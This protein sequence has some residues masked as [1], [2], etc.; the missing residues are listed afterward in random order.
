[1]TFIPKPQQ[2]LATKFNTLQILRGGWY[3]TW[4]ASFLLLVI[5]II[6]INQQRNSIKTVGTDSAPS[7]LTA[8]Q[9]RDSFADLDA[10][11]ANELLAK[12][13]EDP[14]IIQKFEDNRKKIAERLVAAGKNITYPAEE[15]IIQD[16][17]LGSSGYFLK[18]QAARDAHT[19]KDDVAALNIYRSAVSLLERDILPQA[20]NLDRVNSQELEKA[21]SQQ[22]A[23]SKATILSIVLLGIAQIGILIALQL[24]I[25][26]RMRRSFNVSLLGA[27]GLAVVFLLYT[28]ISLIS[29]GNDLKVA[30][31]DAFESIH[32]LRQARALSYMANA[33]ESRYLLDIANSN[34]H[35]RAFKTKINQI[36]SLPPGTS[37]AEV[38]K[39]IPQTDGDVKFVL[40]GFSGLYAKQL[41][42]VTFPGELVRTIDTLNKLDSYLK[43]DAEIRELYRS[44]KVAEAIAL[45]TGKSN[46]VFELYRDANKELRAINEKVF[47]ARIENGNNRLNYFEIIAPIALSSVAIL[48][49]FGVRPRLNEYL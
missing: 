36:I 44:G 47:Y 28:V 3:A 17:Q 23:I 11:L 29:S 1:M 20:E 39:Q 7:I 22:G 21:Y 10:N 31:E 18:L 27:S 42:N 2:K 19:R 40:S 6:G 45:C 25:A 46:K 43:I 41:E 14:A 32:T 26:R 15:K 4:A 37:L 30:K 48:T 5:S 49:L 38:I 9:L 12:P 13:G 16:L 33:D 34:V 24:F 8:Q 35:D